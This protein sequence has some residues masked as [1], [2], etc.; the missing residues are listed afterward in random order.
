MTGEIE[1]VEDPNF[2]RA[3]LEKTNNVNNESVVYPLIAASVWSILPQETASSIG[4]VGF[5]FALLYWLRD[6]VPET[7]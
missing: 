4:L 1:K 2:V 3:M 6:K 7:V 5:S